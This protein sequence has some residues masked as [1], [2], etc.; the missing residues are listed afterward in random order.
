MLD[1]RILLKTLQDIEIKLMLC[2]TTFEWQLLAEKYEKV[3][4]KIE[5]YFND[6]EIPNE[7]EDTLNRTRTALVTKKGNLPPS[8]YSEIFK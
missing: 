8:D 1:S 2:K 7:I 3:S 4:Q 5:V 6:G